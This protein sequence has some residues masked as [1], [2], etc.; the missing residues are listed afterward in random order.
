MADILD[1]SNYTGA[2]GIGF[3]DT[4]NGRDYM[5]QGFCPTASNIT[6]VSFKIN[7]KDGSASIGYAVWIDNADTS[8]NPT[9]TVAVGIGG[10]TEI[11]NSALV[12]GTL[13]KYSLSSQV[14][15]TPGNRYVMCFAPWDTSAHVWTA[16]Y[17]DWVS[18]TANPYA[19]TGF[20]GAKRVHLDGSFAS[21]SAPDAGN[22]DILF[23]TYYQSS[24]TI[25]AASMTSPSIAMQYR[26]EGY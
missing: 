5:V 8:S 16:S 9:G 6:A 14:A 26:T 1:Q 4:G 25:L 21:P 20:T 2:T 24:A 18:S 3:G 12:V 17:N 19:P 11:V 23:E 22:D 13:T 10:F 7:S 15:L